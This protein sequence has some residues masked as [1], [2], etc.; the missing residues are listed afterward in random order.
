MSSISPLAW[1]MGSPRMSSPNIH[2][3][4]HMSTAVEYDVSPSRISGALSSQR[5]SRIYRLHAC[6]SPRLG[7]IVR[8]SPIPKRNNQ[9]RH[10]AQRVPK[11]PRKPKV[12]NLHNAAVVHKQVARLEVAVQHPVGVA[13][14][15]GGEELV[16]E[17]F[18]L[19]LEEGRGHYGE[20]GFQVVFDEVHYYEHPT[21]SI[22]CISKSS[23]EVGQYRHAERERHTASMYHQQ[24][25][26][27]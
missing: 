27:L 1:N 22:K 14:R 18:Y 25:S 12:R 5:I 4:D 19:G 8:D 10:I 16:Q 9:L 15:G 7:Q 23:G 24:R 11:V 20:Q 6:N 17:G 3:T 21:N 26:P 13:V 2:P